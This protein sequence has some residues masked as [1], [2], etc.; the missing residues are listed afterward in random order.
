MNAIEVNN[1]TKIYRLYDSPKD[2]LREMLSFGEKKHHRE[3]YALNNVSFNIEKG[4]TIGIIGQNGSGKSTLLQIISGVLQSTSGSVQTNGR[5]AALLELGAGF[6]PEF[7]GRENVY[8]HGALMGFSRAEMNQRFSD[9][10]KFAEIGDFIDQPVKTY[11]NG[12]YVRLAFASAVNVDPDILVIDEA[13][14]VGDAYFVHRC[15]LR[16]HEIKAKGKTILVVTHDATAVR[17]ICQKVIW[18]NNGSVK[19][20]GKPSD[21]VDQYLAELFHQP[22]VVSKRTSG[23]AFSSDSIGISKYENYIPNMDRRL[24]DQTCSLIGVGL[25]DEWMKPIKVTLNDSWV[26]LR[27]T[28]QNNSLD[29]EM[30]ILVGYVFRNYRGEELASTHSKLEGVEI[31]FC[32]IGQSLSIRM[33]IGLP[34]LYPGTYSFS[35]TLAY[36]NGRKEVVLADRVENALVFE[37]ETKTKVHVL[38]RFKTEIFVEENTASA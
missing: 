29:E 33:K 18:L 30:P 32:K 12:M 21:V 11:S 22:I 26:T 2:R 6:N 19:L 9:I 10:E 17:S 35:P 16:F 25:Y 38:M 14:A 1:L 13:L 31:P 28:F 15:M 7:T 23:V 5:I 8:M 4:Q 36:V 24:G 20:I 34:I 3:F 37:I 27:I